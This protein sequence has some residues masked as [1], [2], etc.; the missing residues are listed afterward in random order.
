MKFLILAFV[1]FG[2]ALARP[3]GNGGDQKGGDQP[4]GDGKEGMDKDL[5]K[6]VVKFCGDVLKDEGEKRDFA[7]DK[8]KL[9]K[10]CFELL[11]KIL[12]IKDNEMGLD[13][14]EGDAPEDDQPEVAEPAL[15]MLGKGP[16]GDGGNR[17]KGDRP[18]GEKIG[19]EL[20]EGV[21]K[22]CAQMFVKEEGKRDFAAAKEELGK[23]CLM[24]FEQLEENKEKL[25]GSLDGDKSESDKPEGDGPNDDVTEDV[26]PTL[27]RLG[28]GGNKPEVQGEFDPEGALRGICMKMIEL[29]EQEVENDDARRQFDS[30]ALFEAMADVCKLLHS[31]EAPAE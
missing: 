29:A 18:E 25:D 24:L 3:S 20:V 5:I 8:A 17:A 21:A 4:E 14:P 11:E 31:V 22:L 7:A 16:D 19:N 13:I 12:E 30:V 15:R 27:R 23:V 2:L 26:A 28:K 10:V 9:Q 1:M 6:V